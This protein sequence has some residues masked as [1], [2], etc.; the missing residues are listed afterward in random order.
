MQNPKIKKVIPSVF[1]FGWLVSSLVRTFHILILTRDVRIIPCVKTDT[2]CG[3]SL[4]TT[5]RNISN[6]PL[7]FEPSILAAFQY[8]PL[9]CIYLFTDIWEHRECG[10]GSVGRNEILLFPE[11]EVFHC[12]TQLRVTC[13]TGWGFMP[14]NRDWTDVNAENGNQ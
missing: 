10:E 9:S 11:Y 8:F 3:L 6:E 13:L 1:S 14:G 12:L 5:A 4:Y 7:C 2:K